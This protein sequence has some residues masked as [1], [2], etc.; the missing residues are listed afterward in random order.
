M[1]SGTQEPLSG[2]QLIDALNT[3]ISE[4]TTNEII[5]TFISNYTRSWGKRSVRHNLIPTRSASAVK[6]LPG[7]WSMQL[8]A[9][10]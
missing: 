9:M 8:K 3:E 10:V 6:K 7:F 4:T 1:T 5:A 2:D